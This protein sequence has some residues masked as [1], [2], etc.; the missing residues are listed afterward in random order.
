M[1]NYIKSGPCSKCGSSDAAAQYS[2]G[3]TY[4][5]SCSTFT[6]AGLKDRLK[7][8][9]SNEKAVKVI[10]TTDWQYSLPSVALDWLD[11][12][13]ITSTEISFYGF[14]WNPNLTS[15][16]WDGPTGA[17]AMPLFENG[18]VVC[19]S[20]R[21]FDQDKPKS[22]TLGYRPYITLSNIEP[23]EDIYRRGSF[24]IVVEDYISALKVSRM[25]PCIPLLG[26]NM[27]D[28]A[29]LRL[30]KAYR[31]VYFWLDEDKLLPAMKMATKAG[32]LGMT[33][34]TIYTEL[35]P[36]DH[37]TE[38]LSSLICNRHNSNKNSSLNN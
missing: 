1:A 25:A 30:S 11:K 27:P 14:R 29:I 23:S 2:D 24:V 18:R 6:G 3:T 12:Y 10:D 38:E 7:P 5:F 28:D 22:I 8:R 31:S 21:L 34:G 20:Y 37:S 17:L 15:K 35:D 9:K 16:L 33:T 4:C 13:G 36:K 32:L 26:S 19:V